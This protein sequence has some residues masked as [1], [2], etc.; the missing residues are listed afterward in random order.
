MCVQQNMKFFIHTKGLLYFVINDQ[1][2]FSAPLLP[3]TPY[4]K[5]GCNNGLNS[6]LVQLLGIS[7][8]VDEGGPNV[9]L[10]N[11]I[12]TSIVGKFKLIGIF[13]FTVA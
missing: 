1:H 13:P 6:D 11:W 5:M 10:R 12:L 4:G 2:K 7:N 3:I 8:T 9:K